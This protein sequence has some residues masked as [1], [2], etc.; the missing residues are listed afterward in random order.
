MLDFDSLKKKRK[1][2]RFCHSV[3]LLANVTVI[4]NDRPV[5]PANTEA[6]AGLQITDLV[7]TSVRFAGYASLNNVKGSNGFALHVNGLSDLPTVSSSVVFERSVAV[8]DVDA[9]VVVD[10]LADRSSVHSAG[11]Y[12]LDAK[13]NSMLLP[14]DFWCADSNEDSAGEDPEFILPSSQVLLGTTHCGPRPAATMPS[15]RHTTEHDEKV[16]PKKLFFLLRI[17][18]LQVVRAKRYKS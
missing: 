5:V 3:S 13:A 16:A 10:S 12:E 18:N 9:G 2:N 6:S 7:G 14:P 17:K 11:R 15:Q 4:E 8:T 1:K